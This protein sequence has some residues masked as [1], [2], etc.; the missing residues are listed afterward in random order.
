MPVSRI[1][2]ID[3]PDLT[4]GKDHFTVILEL[5]IIS[6]PTLVHLE[7]ICICKRAVCIFVGTKGSLVS[8]LVNK[9]NI[10]ICTVHTSKYGL[11]YLSLITTYLLF[12]IAN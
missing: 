7:N 5:L 2:L 9:Y 1:P 4:R 10:C 3:D 8:F 11:M 12:D 6:T